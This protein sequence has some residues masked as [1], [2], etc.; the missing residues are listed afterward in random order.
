V[1]E[2]IVSSSPA[3][4]TGLEL[5]ADHHIS[6]LQRLAAGRLLGTEV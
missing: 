1:R 4:H 6:S 3:R 2:G 5:V